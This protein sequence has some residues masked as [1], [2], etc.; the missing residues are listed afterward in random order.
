[1]KLLKLFYTVPAKYF[2][3]CTI[4]FPGKN[5]CIKVDKFI[6]SVKLY[7]ETK[8]ISDEDALTELS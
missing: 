3:L 2:V 1:M 7:T 8:Q 4:R 6:N 5:Y